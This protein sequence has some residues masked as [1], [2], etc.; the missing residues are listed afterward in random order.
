MK[1]IIITFFLLYV[2]TGCI[3]PEQSAKFYPDK[4]SNIYTCPALSITNN[5]FI[6]DDGTALIMYPKL[7]RS[8]TYKRISKNLYHLFEVSLSND[9]MHSKILV[10]DGYLVS[11]SR[12]IADE[13]IL[14]LTEDRINDS[15]GIKCIQREL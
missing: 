3:N 8:L 10:F 7:I 12:S 15:N 5:T 1:K 13:A 11:F 2:I 9:N 4:F 6:K 14:N